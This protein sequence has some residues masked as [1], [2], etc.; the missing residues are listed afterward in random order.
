[1]NRKIALMLLVA[2]VLLGS[3]SCRR[4]G[5]TGAKKPS[6]AP[7]QGKTGTAEA[8]PPSV[9]GQPPAGTTAQQPPAGTTQPGATAGGTEANQPAARAKPQP[10]PVTE[11]SAKSPSGAK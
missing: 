1:M 8:P 6:K 10:A 3:A 7:A 11:A 5:A 9:G 4:Q 2:A